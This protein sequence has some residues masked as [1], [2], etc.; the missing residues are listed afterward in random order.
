MV[1]ITLYDNN[2]FIQIYELFWKSIEGK[3]LFAKTTEQWM[4]PECSSQ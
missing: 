2:E 3:A 4:K 1:V